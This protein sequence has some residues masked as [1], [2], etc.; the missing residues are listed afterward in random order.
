MN[1]SRR[2][3]LQD[4]NPATVVAQVRCVYC[5]SAISSASFDFISENRRLVSATCPRCGR[6]VTMLTTIWRRETA[7]TLLV[8]E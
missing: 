6:T 3:A 4:R 1:R 5:R 7:R 8:R 2:Q